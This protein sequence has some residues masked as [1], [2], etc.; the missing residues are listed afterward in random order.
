MSYWLRPTTADIGLRAFSSSPERLLIEAAIG[1]Q[2]IMLSPAG[3]LAVEKAI[4]KTGVWNL[5]GVE[6][7][8]WERWLVL[9]LQEVLYKSEVEDM[10]FVDGAIKVSPAGM[11]I[12]ASWVHAEEIELEVEIKAVTMHEL[13][14][15]EVPAGIMMS[16]PWSE[17]P[18]FEGP[19]WVSDVVFDI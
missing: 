19:G 4:R 10:W 11:E 13:L 7:G 2:S 5:T 8:D 1:M 6:E 3:S 15:Q 9:F 17:V 12:V 14:V 16:S 18:S